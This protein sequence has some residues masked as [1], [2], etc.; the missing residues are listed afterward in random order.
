M[1]TR[2]HD[3]RSLVLL[4]CVISS[5]VSAFSQTARNTPRVF[6]SEQAIRAGQHLYQK[7]VE[8]IDAKRAQRISD[9]CSAV[10]LTTAPDDAN[11]F[12]LWWR[13]VIDGFALYDRDG[14]LIVRGSTNAPENQR[15]ASIAHTLCKFVVK[16]E[17]GHSKRA[18]LAVRP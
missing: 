17:T 14:H 16:T 18:S 4:A 7:P 1:L 12:L 15:G 9:N 3:F 10:V 11:Y 6:V 8:P 13:G 2:R 5:A